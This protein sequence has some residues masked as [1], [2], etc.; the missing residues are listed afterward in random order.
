MKVLS[1]VYPL[2][3]PPTASL[4]AAGILLIQHMLMLIRDSVSIFCRKLALHY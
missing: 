4:A 1:L 2:P 3:V